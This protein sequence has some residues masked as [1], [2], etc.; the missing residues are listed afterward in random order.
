MSLS[1]EEKY[2]IKLLKVALCPFDSARPKKKKKSR[3]ASFKN[4]HCPWAHNVESKKEFRVAAMF[5]SCIP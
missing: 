5:L 3:C 2:S 1:S 4:Q